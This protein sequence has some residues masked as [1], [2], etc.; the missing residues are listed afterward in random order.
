MDEK[1]ARL[2][3]PAKEYVIVPIYIKKMYTRV[4]KNRKSLTV[5]KS[6]AAD[7]TAISP[8]VIVLR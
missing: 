3:C 6:I 1:K 5:I 8:V 4:S 7:E 2:G